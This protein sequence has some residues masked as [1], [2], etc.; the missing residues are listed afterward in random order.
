VDDEEVEKDETEEVKE[1]RLTF[2]GFELVCQVCPPS[3]PIF[4]FELEVRKLRGDEN[5]AS[6]PREVQGVPV[7]RA[8]ETR[9]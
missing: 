9:R 4:T 1:M 5:F 8:H 3:L 6:I 2:E 7:N